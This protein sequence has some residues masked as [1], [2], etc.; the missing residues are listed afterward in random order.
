MLHLDT[1]YHP[2]DDIVGIR[3]RKGK[4]EVLIKWAGLEDDEAM[5]WEPLHNI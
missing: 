1:G 5:K 3:K 2:V 4:F